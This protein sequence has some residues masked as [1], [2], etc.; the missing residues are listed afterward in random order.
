MAYHKSIKEQNVY[1]N[2]RIYELRQLEI[3]YCDHPLYCEYEITKNDTNGL[4]HHHL[5]VKC[6]RC[7]HQIGS[8]EPVAISR[9]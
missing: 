6:D 3:L 9:K 8:L 4:T 1:I 5:I 7:N 2:K